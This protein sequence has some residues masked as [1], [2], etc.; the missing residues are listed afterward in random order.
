M[1]SEES[2]S[3]KA[4]ALDSRLV[5]EPTAAFTSTLIDKS[6][7]QTTVGIEDLLHDVLLAAA[8]SDERDTNGVVD[9][10]KSEGDA[11]G[12]RLRG[13]FNGSN[14]GVDFTEQFMAR[15]KRAG[16]S[17]GSAAEEEEVEDRQTDRVAAGEAGNECLLVLVGKFLQVVQ[18]FCVDGVHGGL[19]VLGDLVQKFLLEK[20]I[21]GVFV[22]EGHSALICKEDFPALEIDDI[23][24]ARRGGQ[25]GLGERLGER[26]TRYTH[27]ESAVPGDAGSLAL[28][29]IRTQRRGEGVNVAK[30]EKVWLCFTHGDV[31][32]AGFEACGEL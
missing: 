16:V 27:F 26:T 28:D 6:A 5:D 9:D 14:P 29:N 23:V 11:L 17:V 32:G 25:E 8:S 19:L 12:R 30:C 2:P 24:G 1:V 18:V 20:G 10:W 15:E 4:D 13:V 7:R 22:V 31:C 21:V 3:R